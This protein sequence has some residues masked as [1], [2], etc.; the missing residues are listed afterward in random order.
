MLEVYVGGMAVEVEP[1]HWCFITF[2]CHVTDG[3]KGA[4]WQSGIWHGSAYETEACHWIPPCGKKWHPLTFIN[5]HWMFME[6]KWWMWVQWGS[7]WCVQAE[8]SS[9]SDM[10][11]KP[12]SGWPH[13]A[14]TSWNEEHLNQLLRVNWQIMTRELCTELNFSFSELE[15]MVGML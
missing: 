14:V 2:C 6:T 5:A 8:V 11:D 13:T 1:S 15:M 12:R 3:S 10:K 4:V 7:G 9:F